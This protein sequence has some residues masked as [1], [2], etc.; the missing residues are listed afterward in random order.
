[1]VGPAG[2]SA[3]SPVSSRRR[4]RPGR[5]GGGAPVAAAGDVGLRPGP[6]SFTSRLA[7]EALR[8]RVAMGLLTWWRS[9]S[10]LATSPTG[11]SSTPFS[12]SLSYCR[13]CSYSPP[14]LPSKASTSAPL[15]VNFLGSLCR[16][17]V[18]RVADIFGLPR[19]CWFRVAMCDGP[20]HCEPLSIWIG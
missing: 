18:D 13:S 3:S 5:G 6:C 17:V 7:W 16:P 2:P 8:Y 19:W 11:P 9:R 14:S 20:G 1:M 12:S 15:S 4:R 10:Q